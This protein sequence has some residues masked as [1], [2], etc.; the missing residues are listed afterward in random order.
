M[1]ITPDPALRRKNESLL[2][3]SFIFSLIWGYYTEYQKQKQ[4]LPAK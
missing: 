3:R 4:E 1:A 2:R